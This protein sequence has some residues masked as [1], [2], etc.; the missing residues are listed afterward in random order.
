VVHN[1]IW[2]RGAVVEVADRVLSMEDGQ[3]AEVATASEGI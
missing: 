1:S 3:L 2:R